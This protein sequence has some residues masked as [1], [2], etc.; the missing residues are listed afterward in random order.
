MA[1]KVVLAGAALALAGC[2]DGRL[3]HAAYVK[4]ADAVCSAFATRVPLLTR[5]KS[6]D[7]VAAYVERTLPLYAD[8]LDKLKAL[9]PPRADEPAVQAWLAAD[10]AVAAALRTLRAAALRKDPAATND[11]ANALQGRSLDARKA[12][13]ALGLQACASP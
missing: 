5:P 11:A 9:K 8:A 12:A 10:A 3:S 6:Y 4:R 13:S 2:G 1:R 7:A